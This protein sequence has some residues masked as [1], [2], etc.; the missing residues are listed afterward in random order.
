M[1]NDPM[2]TPY[3]MRASPVPHLTQEQITEIAMVYAKILGISKRT[4]R[5][6]PEFVNFNLCKIAE[7]L[8]VEPIDDEEWRQEWRGISNA[9]YDPKDLSI[10][11]SENLYQNL[12]QGKPLSVGVFAHELGHYFLNHDLS[13]MHFANIEVYGYCREIDPEWQ[14]DTFAAVLCSIMGFDFYNC[15]SE[16]LS[17][18]K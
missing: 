1:N 5:R 14:A 15:D 18:F 11:M 16:Q 12:M 10:K 17:L 6:I 13:T 9:S 3:K 7:D 2:C 8:S 4:L